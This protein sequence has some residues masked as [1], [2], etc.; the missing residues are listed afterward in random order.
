VLVK[1]NLKKLDHGLGDMLFGK[2]RALER[3]AKPFEAPRYRVILFGAIMMRAGAKIR[4]DD[5]KHLRELVPKVPSREGYNRPLNDDC[6]RGPRRAH[7]LAALEH[8][9]PGVPR[10]FEEPRLIGGPSRAMPQRWCQVDANP[11]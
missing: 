5:M 6:F 9:Q 4:D 8:Y 1:K 7:F 10:N 3:D 2:Y 11:G